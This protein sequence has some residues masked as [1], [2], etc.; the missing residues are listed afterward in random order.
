MPGNDN[1]LD[2]GSSF[3]DVQELLVSIMAFDGIFLHQAVSAVELD[4]L[5]GHAMIHFGAE[6]LRHGGFLGEG[7][8]LL[9]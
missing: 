6:H 3:P 8:M 1:P 5:V 4:C 7:A 2:L 9:T